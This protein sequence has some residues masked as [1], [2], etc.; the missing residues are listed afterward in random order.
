MLQLRLERV[1]PA[2]AEI[3]IAKNEFAKLRERAAGPY[4][5]RVARSRLALW[6]RRQ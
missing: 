3:A 4:L 5:R 1:R 2:M 6:D